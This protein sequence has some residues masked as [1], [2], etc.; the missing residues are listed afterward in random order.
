MRQVELDISAK[1]ARPGQEI[2]ITVISKPNSYIGLLGVDQNV[3]SLR[4][5]N[6]LDK[7]QIFNE[8]ETYSKKQSSVSRY[9]GV[10]E[11]KDFA[12]YF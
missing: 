7:M 10:D 8:L 5:G 11:W 2:D 1:Q 12:V 3:L 4:E 6:D 9:Y